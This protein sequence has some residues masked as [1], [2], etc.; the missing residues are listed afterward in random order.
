MT[1]Q[2]GKIRKRTLSTGKIIELYQ[3][4]MST[5]EI[6]VKANV[7]S[8]YIRILLKQN[9]VQLRPRGSW[10]RKYEFNEDYFKT[11]SNNMAY[12]LGFFIADGTV[13]RDGQF[14]SFAQKEKYILENI[15]QEIGSDQP[16]Y[17]NKKTGVYILNFNSKIMKADLIDIH[18]VIPDK[19][20]L[21]TLPEVPDEYM[22]HFIRG[23]FDGDGYINYEQYTV[24]FVGGS[25]LFMNQLNEIL[26][27][28]RLRTQYVNDGKNVRLHIRGR[29]SIKRFSDWIYNNKDRKLFL[30]RKYEIF[31]REKLKA[32]DLSD[33]K[34][35]NTIAA[36]EK[37]KLNFLTIFSI[38][39]S[40]EKACECIGININTYKRWL[41]E[42]HKFK[43]NFDVIWT[44]IMKG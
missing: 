14:V 17:Q 16:L 26:L 24:T 15:K 28:K 10:K 42:D 35:I 20:R 8:R 19:S 38:L 44:Y 27:K 7:S 13:A 30:R 9:K 18:G 37:R 3:K 2:T 31:A 12:I 34:D 5:T 23:Y 40:E 1:N 11:W 41:K 6:A 33:S 22:S 4:G 36:I 21:I 32:E 39:V 43:F 25:K 29:Q